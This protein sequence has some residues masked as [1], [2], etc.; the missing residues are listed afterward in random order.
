MKQSN[1]VNVISMTCVRVRQV[2]GAV[3]E[4]QVS[5]SVRAVSIIPTTTGVMFGNET[6][7]AAVAKDE[8]L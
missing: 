2:A 6:V 7:K 1:R 8:F 5:T 4:M 3:T